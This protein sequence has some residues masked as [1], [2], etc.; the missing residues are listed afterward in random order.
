MRVVLHLF[1]QSSRISRKRA[2]L[3]IASIAWGTVS[4]L[5]L[6]SFGEGLKRQFSKN[7]NS[8]G[9]NIAVMWPSETTKSWKGMPPGRPIRLTLDD[10]DYVRERMP[11]LR[12]VL[13]EVVSWRTN[14]AYGPKT[15]NGRVLGTQA[16]YGETRRH[17]A[18]AGGRFFNDGDEAEKR[19]V[20]FLGDELAKDIFGKEDPVG[21]TLLLN[22]SPFTVIG[23]MVHKRQM[24]VY[25]GPDENHAVI[26]STTFKALFGRDRLNVLV[27]E[28][29]QPE[30]MAGALKRLNEILGS[31]HGYDPTDDRALA[32]WNIVKTSQIN[33]NVALGLQIFLG[34]IGVLTLVIGGVGVANIMFAVVKERTREIGVKMALGARTSWITGPFVLEGLVYTLVGGA[35]GML[36]ALLLVTP[37]GYLPIEKNA[38]LEFLGR[39]TLSPAIGFVT[40]AVLGLIGTLAG[41]FPARR[42]AA[43]DPAA[44]LRY[45]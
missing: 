3:T 40:A 12:S 33:R 10:V 13:G 6:L 8:T 25:G 32:T 19:R 41:Y 2:F 29:W 38:V 24:G 21:R 43:I 22:N 31:K 35:A 44:T 15:V 9:G 26:P 16:V 23:V 4:I 37:L 30:E 39:P 28:T 14:L 20:V 7:R 27:I 5:L 1:L 18:V 34:I 17:Y 42:A 36:I 11:E 45:E